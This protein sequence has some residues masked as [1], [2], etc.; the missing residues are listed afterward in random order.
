MGL[1]GIW[2]RLCGVRDVAAD[3]ARLHNNKRANRFRALSL[4]C[5]LAGVIIPQAAQA[6]LQ[7]VPYARER[8]GIAI[9]GNAGTWWNQAKGVYARGSTPRSGAVLA[10]A[11]SSAMPIGHVAVVNKVID[12]RHILLDH[13]NWSAPGKI[14][15]EVLAEDV[16][17][18]GDWSAVRV[19]FARIHA[20]GT[21]VNAVQ[22][23][24]YPTSPT[25]V[26]DRSDF[27]LASQTSAPPADVF[28][29]FDRTFEDTHPA[30]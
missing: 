6:R 16:S 8:S 20:L 4:T 1:V 19:W 7:C 18:A 13:A 15:R 12:E 28:E 27:Q 21:R 11:P 30:G 26:P 22:G 24:I 2:R 10:I 29:A 23:F 17:E 14:E 3:K 25:S 5:A 9:F